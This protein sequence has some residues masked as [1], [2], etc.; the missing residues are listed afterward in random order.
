MLYYCTHV[1]TLSYVTVA[2]G[3]EKEKEIYWDKISIFYRN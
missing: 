2:Q 1:Y 3:S